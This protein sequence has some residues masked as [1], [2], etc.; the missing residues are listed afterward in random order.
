[1]LRRRD[2]QA[3]FGEVEDIPGKGAMR[4]KVLSGQ[5]AGWSGESGSEGAEARKQSSLCPVGRCP[6]Q[7]I[8]MGFPRN[9][10]KVGAAVSGVIYP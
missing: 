3:G 7:G 10:E 8:E 5:A 4:A 6:S 1:M 9:C 2:L